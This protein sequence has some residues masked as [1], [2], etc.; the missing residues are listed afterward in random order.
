MLNYTSVSNDTGIPVRTVREHY[1][2]LEDTLIGFQLPPFRRSLKRKP[3]ATAKFYFFDVGVPNTLRK[4]GEII[5]GSELYGPALE[6][7][8]YLHLRAILVFRALAQH[9]TFW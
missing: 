3:V 9:L 8:V 1:Q 6:H 2:M 4:R 5:P 7:P